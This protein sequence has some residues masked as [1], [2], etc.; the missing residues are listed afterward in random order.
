MLPLPSVAV[1]GVAAASP[2]VTAV[3]SSALVPGAGGRHIPLEQLAAIFHPACFNHGLP[4]AVE[5]LT[6]DDIP[7]SMT[8]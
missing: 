1:R 6:S 4:E 8:R 5:Q 3:S 2:R 7:T